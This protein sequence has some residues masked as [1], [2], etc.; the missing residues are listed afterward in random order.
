MYQH[1]ADRVV[2][3][4]NRRRLQRMESLSNYGDTLTQL[5]IDKIIGVIRHHRR[6]LQRG[7]AGRQYAHLSPLLQ[8]APHKTAA[9]AMR[10][11][12]D[13]ISSSTRLHALAHEVGEKLWLET[14][15]CRSTRWERINHK[16]VRGHFRLKVEDVKRMQHTEI[17]TPMERATVGAF[18]VSL[19]AE[20]T[21]LITVKKER[22]GMRTP[23]VVQ[24]TKACLEFINK[25]EQ[26]SKLLCPFILPAVVVPRVWVSPMDGGYYTPIPNNVLIKDRPEL[27]AQHTRG[28]E[29]YLRAANH[30]QSVAWQVN[31]WMLDQVRHAWDKNIAVGNLIPREG[32]EIPPYPK[33][34]PDDHA[35]VTQ[36]KFNAR[37]IHEKNDKTKNKRIGTAKQLWIAGRMADE[38]ELYYPMQLDFRGRYYY[39][40]AFLNPQANDIGRSLLQF[41]N[42]KPITTE[43]EAD[44]L[45]VHGANLY[46]HSKLS[47]QARRDWAI[48]NREAIRSTGEDPWFMAEWWT[49]ADDPWQF[50][51][52]CRAASQYMNEGKTYVCQLP[53]VLDCTCSGIQHY[54]A[55]LRSP[56]MAQ[57]V[58]LMPSDKPQDIY[59]A[60]LEAVLQQLR[61]DAA[62][63][64]PIA[65]SWLEL[66]P[67]R[68]LAKPVV[69]TLPYS[70]SRRAVFQYCQE[71]AFERTLDIYGTSGWCFN[72]GAM[73]GM[74]YMATILGAETTKII[75]PAKQAMGWFKSVGRIAGLTGVPLHWTSPSGLHVHQEYMDMRGVQINLQHLSSV[76]MNL[77]SYHK[78]KGLNPKRMGNAL[79]PNV[80]HSM[81]ASHMALATC[82]AFDAGV[83]NLG[84]IHDCFA[85]TPAEMSTVRD[86]VRNSFADMY[87]HDWYTEVTDQLISQLPDAQ[88]PPRPKLGTLD[89]NH[90]RSATYFIT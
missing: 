72:K 54:S 82:A 25:V 44:W 79:S 62:D 70:A 3:L 76:V 71:W 17:W 90:V 33:H 45:W 26:E 10:V 86:A 31:T 46:G 47:W 66:Q 42:G 60:V 32:W 63:G 34:L 41:A 51:A 67:D 57:L 20:H 1:G 13:Q 49:G 9:C 73:A 28:D 18:M 12:V 85:T 74:H 11:V 37:R 87:S 61:K 80:I 69:M 83:T 19:I 15:L 29:P 5:G 22:Y 56:E 8:L 53:V 58:N 14:M 88:L 27:V 24:P 84:G 55:L 6:Q 78:P 30:Q 65:V 7:A 23:Y 68:S 4:G 59:S 2:L 52:F 77:R 43:Q 21:G 38:P 39:R 36:W 50:L 81:D 89:V 75:G 16:R 64:N 35:D 48:Q 40:P